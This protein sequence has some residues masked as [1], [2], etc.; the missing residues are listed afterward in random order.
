MIYSTFSNRYRPTLQ[1]HIHCYENKVNLLTLKK[2]LLVNGSI[3]ITIYNF[4]YICMGRRTGQNSQL[5]LYVLNFI[6][7]CST[8]FMRAKFHL[9]LLNFIYAC[10]TLFILPQPFSPCSTFFTMLNFYPMLNFGV[11]AIRFDTEVEFD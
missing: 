2:N 1:P 4:L 7:T 6:Y 5:H 3:F 10:S 9:C 8:S 11:L